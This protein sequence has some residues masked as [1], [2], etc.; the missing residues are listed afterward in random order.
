MFFF[1]K[2]S[3]IPDSKIMGKDQEPRL[4]RVGSPEREEPEAYLI[5]EGTTRLGRSRGFG[6]C[7][8]DTTVSRF[9]C[10][11][12]RN[13]SVVHVHDGESKNPARIGGEKVNGQRLKRGQTLRVGR[14][15][16]V[17]E[18]PAPSPASRTSPFGTLPRRGT[19][20]SRSR[21]SARSAVTRTGWGSM[22]GFLVLL[23]L[24]A[25]GL[26]WLGFSSPFVR[27]DTNS[28]DEVSLDRLDQL[29]QEIAT[30]RATQQRHRQEAERQ[31]AEGATA[32]EHRRKI[33]ALSRRVGELQAELDDEKARDRQ[34]PTLSA[35]RQ[36]GTFDGGQNEIDEEAAEWARLD[37]E[38]ALLPERSKS[39]LSNRGQPTTETTV[40][41]ELPPR[42]NRTR[43]EIKV[44]VERL[45]G[46]IDDYGTQ[47]VLPSSL[48]PE[49]TH[50][51]H[52]LGKVAAAGTL[53][54]YEHTHRLL[55]Q[56]QASIDFNKRRK[57]E[58][59]RQARRTEGKEPKS[60][61][62]KTSRPGDYTK[63]AGPKVEADQRLLELSEK[64]R[65]IHESQRA[66]LVHLK[67]AVL[68][69][70]ENLTDPEALAYLRSRFARE[71]DEELCLAMLPAFE[72]EGFINAIPTL[73][74]KL[75][76]T[77]DSIFK[78]T[79]RKTL[80]AL[81]GTDLG[82]KPSSWQDW[83]ATNRPDE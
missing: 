8:E 65:Q 18:G 43:A 48:E 27:K 6:I 63:Q 60:D 47:L 74:R 42:F 72:S 29:Q 16:F 80:T 52:S 22:L 1:G 62:G 21:P 19:N 64:A 2:P 10:Y 83:W 53:E 11:F 31:E 49:L 61:K 70:V 20:R 14:C 46:R 34:S 26:L 76:S 66:Y 54:V 40:V 5:P 44:L 7:L 12:V 69:S 36:E 33:D 30:L 38:F 78:N 32:S 57:E 39:S 23:L 75:G 17:Y 55:K 82:Q 3:A 68:A 35:R 50:L 41:R 4:V 51:S 37:R 79:I 58:L 67:D 77:K 71:T 81:V 24:I 25:G 28:P 13:G 15:E 73:S 59:L 9:H 56:T 45:C